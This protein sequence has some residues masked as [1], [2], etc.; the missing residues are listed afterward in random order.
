VTMVEAQ[1]GWLPN[2]YVYLTQGQFNVSGGI[3]VPKWFDPPE[4]LQGFSSTMTITLT[5]NTPIDVSG[6]GFED[7]MPAGM[8]LV[9]VTSN[10]CL[11][12]TTSTADNRLVF[13]RGILEAGA[14]CQVIATVRGDGSGL[15]TNT[16]SFISAAEFNYSNQGQAS[17]NVLQPS[18][19]P[20]PTNV[21]PEEPVRPRPVC[22]NLMCEPGE[23]LASCV[24]D[25]G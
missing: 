24:R 3:I 18:A 16:T 20:L 6:V 12:S 25:C 19:T 22:G 21:P 17:L 1:T 2:G 23:T 11:R 14:S 4:V 15:L 9:A 7:P 5:N 13:Q 8:F 10:T